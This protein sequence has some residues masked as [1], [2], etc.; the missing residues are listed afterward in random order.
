MPT[1]KRG[2]KKTGTRKKLTA[3]ALTGLL[4]GTRAMD[5]RLEREAT[6]QALAQ[7]VRGNTAI[8]GTVNA[9]Q[10]LDKTIEFP[11]EFRKGDVVSVQGNQPEYERYRLLGIPIPGLRGDE[12]PTP[13]ALPFQGPGEGRLTGLKGTVFIPPSHRTDD[14]TVVPRADTPPVGPKQL[15]RVSPDM[16]RRYKDLYPGGQH[17]ADFEKLEHALARAKR[18]GV[19][20]SYR[21]PAGE[22]KIANISEESPYAVARAWN[23]VRGNI[24]SETKL[25]QE[26]NKA[27]KKLKQEED[28]VNAA[29]EKEEKAKEKYKKTVEETNRANSQLKSVLTTLAAVGV[30]A[31]PVGLPAASLLHAAIPLGVSAYSMLNYGQPTKPTSVSLTQ[32]D[33]D[34]LQLAKVN[35]NT[36]LQNIRNKYQSTLPKTSMAPRKHSSGSGPIT[37]KKSRKGKKRKTKSKK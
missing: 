11:R 31:N 2:Q 27:L 30:V 21:L 6:E 18:D 9:L 5:H 10:M 24:L 15:A 4:S 1:K 32:Q 22:S 23:E 26:V 3:A 36:A 25:R 19:N 35:Y 17:L 29:V 13:T 14:L 33:K 34:E 20:W 12:I 7:M 28:K 8:P 37:R 16:L